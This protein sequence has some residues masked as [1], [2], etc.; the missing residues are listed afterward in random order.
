[1]SV[2]L[3]YIN[4]AD[5]AEALRIGR[6]L[7]ESGL[8][9]GLNV[10]SEVSSIYRWHGE[11]CEKSEAL[12]VVKTQSA[13]VDDVVDRVLALHSYECPSVVAVP[14]SGGNA[15]YL[16]WVVGETGSAT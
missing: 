11:V 6:A 3:V 8:A 10:I 9:A 13:L 4:A 2:S 12:L 16:D 1:M 7:V 5:R 15:D 14:V